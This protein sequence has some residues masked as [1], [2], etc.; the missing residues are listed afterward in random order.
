MIDLHTHILPGIDDGP[1]DWDESM[2]LARA[3]AEAGVTAVAATSHIKPPNWNN[4]SKALARLRGELSE[5]LAEAEVPLQIHPGAEH[6]WCGSV[7]DRLLKGGGQPYGTGTAVLLEFHP[8]EGPRLFEERLRRLWDKGI[9]V[10]LAHVERYQIFAGK[11]GFKK[12]HGLV[13]RG[14]V[15]QVNL[16]SLGRGFGWSRGGIAKKM[17]QAGLVGLVCGD[18]HRAQDVGPAYDRGLKALEKLGGSAAVERLLLRNPE[19]LL[20]GIEVDPWSPPQF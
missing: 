14:L 18:C 1:L 17:L 12:L 10:V 13:E 4:R 19:R 20:E 11:A 7:L 16:G 5:R 8:L 3:L 15:A 2:A 9:V 6:W